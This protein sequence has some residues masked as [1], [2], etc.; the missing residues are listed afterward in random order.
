M[1]AVTHAEIIERAELIGQKAL[2]EVAEAERNGCFSDD[3]RAAVHAAEIHKLL[4]PKRYGGFG[5]GARTFSEM[6]RVVAQYN[7]SAAW[8]VYFTALHEQWVAFLPPE[9]RQEIYD[10]DGF[11]AD[12]FFPIGKVEY[13]EGGVKL[14]GEWLYGSGVGWDEWIGLGAFVEVPGFDQRQP[15]LVTVNTSEVEITREWAPFGLRGTGSY[16]VKADGVFVPWRRVLPLAHVK[17]TGEPTG[18]EFDPEEPIYRAPFMP[19]FTLGFTAL[20]VGVTQT[21]VKDLRQRIH[22][23]ERVLYGMKEW[24][25]PV[26]QRNLAEIMVQLDTIE[27]LNERYVRQIEEWTE[28][29]TPVV[30]DEDSNRM[31]AWRSS[32]CKTASDIAFRSLELLGG[33]AANVGDPLEIAARDL[34]MILI[35][36]GQIYEDNMLAYGRTQYGL[37]GHPLL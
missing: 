15:C 12:I 17:A 4:R 8:L 27:A 1:T 7:A 26:A 31:N 35:H 14:S 25:S 34:F 18:G 37:S 20:S 21:V 19:F 30:P 33:T 10:S 32:I 3:L 23:R 36:V 28:A 24:E 5:M 6:V 22:D 29:G 16:P 13:V 9:G 2:A 11:T